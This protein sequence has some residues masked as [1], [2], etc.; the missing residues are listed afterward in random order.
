MSEFRTFGRRVWFHRDHV[1]MRHALFWL[2][3]CLAWLMMAIPPF[4]YLYLA[5][6]LLVLIVVIGDGSV[7]WPEESWPFFSIV[8]V[9]LVL[10]PLIKGEGWRDLYLT[11]SGIAIVLL[12]DWPKLRLWTVMWA[13]L[14]AFLFLYLV[15][16]DLRHGI[17]FDF[18][19]S[20]STFEGNFSF[21]FA[22]LAPFAFLRKRYGLAFLALFLTVLTLKRIAVVAAL[23]GVLLVMLGDRRTKWL[24]NW[25]S[26]VV[27]NLLALAIM[28]AYTDGS[29]DA[30]I[31]E[32]T[33]QSANQFVQGRVQLQSAVF[34]RIASEPWLFILG[35]GAGSVYDLTQ[36]GVWAGNKWLLHCDSL[37]VMY[38]FGFIF[39]V[40]FFWTIYQSKK[41][42]IRLAGAVLNIMILTDNLLAYNF[43]IVYYLMVLNAY[44][45]ELAS[46]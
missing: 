43:F 11:L 17:R 4:R 30:L 40:F 31:F 39:W 20:E 28:K 41:F 32:W 29:F 36:G 1:S 35:Q 23:F 5:I 10:F 9:A 22:L 37:L 46:D 15:F 18:L 6:P 25:R 8:A 12:K 45:Q 14:S 33:G 34:A 27:L 21:V 7:R 44:Q 19:R 24:L 3:F 13:L 16:G 26:M 2:A 38:E 42:Y